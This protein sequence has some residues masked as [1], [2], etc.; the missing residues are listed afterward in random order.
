MLGKF[1][2]YFGDQRKGEA[3]DELPCV[4]ACVSFLSLR[5]HV[6]REAYKDLC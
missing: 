4:T 1:L 2:S 3:S 5:I 6:T